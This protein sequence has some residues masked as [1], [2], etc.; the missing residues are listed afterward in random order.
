MVAAGLAGEADSAAV[1]GE[2]GNFRNSAGRVSPFCAERIMRL[3][4]YLPEY[5]FVETHKIVINSKS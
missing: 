1:E 5:D 2:R 3:D 4:Y